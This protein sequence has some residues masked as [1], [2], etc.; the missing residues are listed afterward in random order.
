[1]VGLQQHVG[2]ALHPVQLHAVEK[3][4]QAV[5]RVPAGREE[6]EGAEGGSALQLA[7][8]A[9]VAKLALQPWEGRWRGTK[10]AHLTGWMKQDVKTGT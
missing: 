5:T 2:G 6:R 3:V 4:A 9:G 7:R 1:M 8:A 10:A